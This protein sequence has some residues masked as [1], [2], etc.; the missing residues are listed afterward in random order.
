MRFGAALWL[1]RTS[2][3]EVRDAALAAEAVGWDAVYVDDHLLTDEGEWTGARFEGWSILA[4]LASLTNRVRLGLLVGANT[5]RNPGLTAKLASTLDHLSAGRTILGLGAGWFER[6][7][8]AFGIPFLSTAGER[9][10]RLDEAVGII[11]RLLD[12]ERFDHVG[13]FYSLRD[14][15]IAP[16]PIQ[17]RLPMLIG[18]SG[19]RKTLRTTAR[20]A[21]MWNG[22]GDPATIARTSSQLEERCAEVGRRYADIE[23]SVTLDIVIRDD[24]RTA[25]VAYANQLAHHGIDPDVGTSDPELGVAVGGSPGRVADYVGRYAELGLSE[26]VFV[27]RTPFDRPTIERLPEVRAVL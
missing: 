18:G 8:S 4:S 11:R 20:Y 1:N 26:I 17:P 7:H 27:F 22:Y 16:R 13:A 24:L 6:E 25:Q 23:R 14:G 19:P 9:L 5:F 10:D 3:P 12:G 15:L 2:W 21:D